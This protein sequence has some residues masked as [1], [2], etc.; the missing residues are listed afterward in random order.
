MQVGGVTVAFPF[1]LRY[2]NKD[3]VLIRGER[4]NEITMYVP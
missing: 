4:K 2:G 3:K 1:L